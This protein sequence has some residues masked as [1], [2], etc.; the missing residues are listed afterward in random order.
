MLNNCL[1]PLADASNPR[2]PEVARAF[3][4][5]RKPWIDVNAASPAAIIEQV[6]RCPSGALS[7][8][9]LEKA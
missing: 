8:E 9:L 4:L 2:V 7:Y 6:K 5:S 1:L 3:S